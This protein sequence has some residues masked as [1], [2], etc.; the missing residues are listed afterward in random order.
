[1]NDTYKRIIGTKDYF[2]TSDGFVYRKTG[3]Y[4]FKQLK[5]VSNNKTKYC[6]VV[7]RYKDGQLK[8]KKIH[9]LVAA[10][11][12]PKPKYARNL[13]INHIDANKNNNSVTNL[14]WVTRKQNMR[15]A[16]DMGLC[17][18]VPIAIRKKRASM[19]GQRTELTE[20][21]VRHIRKLRK[22]G[23]KHREIA[24]IYNLHPVHVCGIC[25]GRMWKNVI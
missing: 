2:V 23:F 11:F 14:N 17:D 5:A 12:L 20:D 22:L 9:Q 21:D 24:T 18:N 15:H 10:A 6:Q 16:W 4:T 8:N 25:N 7:I 19:G 13:E 1:M 3:E